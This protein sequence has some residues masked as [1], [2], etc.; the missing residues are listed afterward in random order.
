MPQRAIHKQYKLNEEMMT[1]II[2]ALTAIT[3]TDKVTSEKALCW[4]KE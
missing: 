3:E 2:R 4:D 1:E